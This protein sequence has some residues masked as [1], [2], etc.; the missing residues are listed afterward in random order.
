M[1]RSPVSGDASGD[2]GG[3][4]EHGVEP[5]CLM[6]CFKAK[7]ELSSCAQKGGFPPETV[8]L[9]PFSPEKSANE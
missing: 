3:M 2:D 1:S 8:K 9:N 6:V 4:L 7:N 5:V